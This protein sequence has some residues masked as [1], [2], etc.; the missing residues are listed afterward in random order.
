MLVITKEKKVKKK[1][2]GVEPGKCPCGCGEDLKPRDTPYWKIEGDV[3]SKTQVFGEGCREDDNRIA[4]AQR[5]LHARM[6]EGD[7]DKALKWASYYRALLQ[8]DQEGC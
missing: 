8:E 1:E 2:S 3:E 5:G 7:K 6:T 4:N